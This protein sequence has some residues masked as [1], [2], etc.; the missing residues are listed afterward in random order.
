MA[1][2]ETSPSRLALRL[3]K[4][5]VVICGDLPY[6]DA[7]EVR[8]SL[9]PPADKTRVDDFLAQSES[10]R[11][12]PT[13]VNMYGW[14]PL[15][16]ASIIGNRNVVSRLLEGPQTDINARDNEGMTALDHAA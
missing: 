10:P 6:G 5:K 16:Q 2:Q 4:R 11:R 12:Q 1:F 14:T 8:L 15:H 3:G 13:Y 9:T 7:E